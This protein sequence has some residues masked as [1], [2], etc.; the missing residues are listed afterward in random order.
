MSEVART[1]VPLSKSMASIQLAGRSS[2]WINAGCDP[3]VKPEKGAPA[4]AVASFLRNAASCK[5]GRCRRSS[6]LI[7]DVHRSAGHSKRQKQTD[8]APDWYAFAFSR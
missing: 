5:N 8:R 4:G 1:T 2:E 3:A 6:I 7:A